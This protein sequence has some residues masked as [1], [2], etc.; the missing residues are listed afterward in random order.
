[1]RDP[2]E[3]ALPTAELPSHCNRGFPLEI[4][5]HFGYRVLRRNPDQHVHMI[6]YHV[7]FENLTS[8]LTGQFM[9]HRSQELSHL[10]VEFLLTT[11][12]HKHDVVFAVPFGMT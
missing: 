3:I 4:P 5:D 11:L 2:V 10:A 9:K 12:G 8:A 7:T 1:M 6:L